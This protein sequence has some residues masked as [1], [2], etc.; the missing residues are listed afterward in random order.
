[1]I[2]RRRLELADR[3][4]CGSLQPY[5]T[6][7]EMRLED[8]EAFLKS[9][10]E[11]AEAM[12]TSAVRSVVSDMS[13][14]GFKAA[15]SC[16]LLGSGRPTVDVGATLRS[17]AMIHTA[18][19]HLFREAI[20]KACGSCGLPVVGVKEKE[21]ISRAITAIGVSTAELQRRVSQVG[22]SIGPPWRQDEKLC[23]IAS[24]LVLSD[25]S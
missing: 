20:A 12:A 9:C 13:R 10:A 6:A 24:W 14:A 23:T 19:G 2:E 16:I 15:G 18:E 17:H 1:M 21:L 22:K 3:G 7:K 11:V 25:F 8:A 4:V 5:H